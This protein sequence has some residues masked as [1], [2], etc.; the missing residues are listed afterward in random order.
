M[1]WIYVAVA[2]GVAG[3]AVLGFA[4]AR[5]LTEA[6]RLSD[7]VRRASARIASSEQTLRLRN[8]AK[9]SRGDESGLPAA[10]DRR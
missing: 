4:T 3:L 10:Y 1:S 9:G 5:V 8:G 7:E 2:L 6:R